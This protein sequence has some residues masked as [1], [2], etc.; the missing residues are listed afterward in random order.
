MTVIPRKRRADQN[1]G[2]RATPVRD[3]ET[4]PCPAWTGNHELTNDAGANTY[5]AR[6]GVGWI[7]LDGAVR[8]T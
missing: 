5:C 4:L 2:R 3:V 8:A 1:T 6:C 7:G